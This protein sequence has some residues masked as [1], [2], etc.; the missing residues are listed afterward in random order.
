[1]IRYLNFLCLGDR[2]EDMR[3]PRARP[4]VGS[5]NL[6]KRFLR[7]KVYFPWMVTLL[8]SPTAVPVS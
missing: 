3:A 1:M 2:L 5:R 6:F 8:G 7:H 4:D